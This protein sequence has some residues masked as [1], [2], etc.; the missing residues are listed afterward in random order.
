LAERLIIRG[1]VAVDG[2]V[3]ALD[4]LRQDIGVEQ[5]LFTG[6]GPPR[7]LVSPLHRLGHDLV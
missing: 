1:G 3:E 4:D 5:R 2:R 7:S 6:D